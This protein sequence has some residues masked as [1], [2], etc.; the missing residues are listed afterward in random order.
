MHH[1]NIEIKARCQQLDHIRQLLLDRGAESRG[2]DHQI[3]TY[4]NVPTGRLKL[5][6][7]NIENTLIFYQRTE[8]AGPKQSAI[9][10]AEVPPQSELKIVLAQALGVLV[11]VDKQRAIYF[12]GNV[13]FHLDTVV[14]LGTFVEI[15]V[16]DSDGS[17]TLPQ[18]RAQCEEYCRLFGLAP[19][20]YIAASYSDLLL[21]QPPTVG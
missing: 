10:L 17:H 1:T 8:Q 16:I 20:E 15:E 21:A 3:D 18:L 11:M 6:Q 14:G 4:F 5:R 13:K 12:M 2:T 19:A 7:G 9:T